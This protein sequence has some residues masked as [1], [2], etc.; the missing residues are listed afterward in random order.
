M[1]NR[2][3]LNP[4]SQQA[5]NRGPWTS[6]QTYEVI[7]EKRQEKE[8]Q[9]HKKSAIG[10]DKSEI[11]GPHASNPGCRFVALRPGSQEGQGM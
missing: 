4:V 8:L 11:Y 9:D 5:P 2:V 6:N 1:R 7:N 10:I 3:N